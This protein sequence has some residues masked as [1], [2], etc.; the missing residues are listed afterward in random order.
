MGQ[1]NFHQV[2][3]PFP[4]VLAVEYRSCIQILI[5]HIVETVDPKALGFLQRFPNGGKKKAEDLVC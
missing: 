1:K 2:F 5:D 4:S 3:A